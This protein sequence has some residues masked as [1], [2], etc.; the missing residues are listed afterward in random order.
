MTRNEWAQSCFKNVFSRFRFYLITS[1]IV[2]HHRRGTEREGTAADRDCWDFLVDD[3]GH[4]AFASSGM[5]GN[6]ADDANL[7]GIAG[8]CAADIICI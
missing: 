2:G 1:D 3:A 6:P 4:S 8:T 5:E 7:A